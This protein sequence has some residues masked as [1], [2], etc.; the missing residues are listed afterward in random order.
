M[1]TFVHLLI[2]GTLGLVLATDTPADSEKPSLRKK[3]AS[4]DDSST[5]SVLISGPKLASPGTLVVL[6][7]SKSD[8]DTFVWKLSDSDPSF[9]ALSDD[10]KT[11]Y[12]ASPKPGR[13]I[14]NLAVA[15][16]SGEKPPLLLL[17]EH[18]VTLQGES[19]KPDNPVKPDI[20][21]KPDDLFS[22]EKYGM[23]RFT[24]QLILNGIPEEKRQIA[25]GFSANYTV[26]SFRLKNGLITDLTSANGELKLRNQKTAG[27]DIELWKSKVFVF[28]GEKLRDMAKQG[29]INVSDS[30]VLA[31]VFSEISMG[32]A[33][34]G[35]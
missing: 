1:K 29:V 30:S 10:G 28:L 25:W 21:P 13:Y 3:V 35:N 17:S 2:V 8:A 26:V 16:K 20:P 14:F 4:V 5:I 18:V 9:Y 6:D 27:S 22:K 12:F 7:A 11:V 33:S 15:K 24:Q 31:E 19:P 32:F 34:A 23:G